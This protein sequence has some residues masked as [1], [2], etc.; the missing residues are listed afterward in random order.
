MNSL[1]ENLD[2]S[3]I[4]GTGDLIQIAF[5]L[6]QVILRFEEVTMMIDIEAAC[7]VRAPGGSIWIWE[8]GKISDMSGFA[9]LLESRIQSYK[10]VSKSEL[11]IAFT[12]GYELVLHEDPNKLESFSI[13]ARGSG[14]IV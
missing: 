6:Y 11:L 5:S 10:I 13:G 8:P 12:T 7:E 9:K 1:H 4:L 2:L 3:Y 14:L